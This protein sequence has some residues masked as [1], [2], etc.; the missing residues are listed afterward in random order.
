MPHID[1][2]K[3]WQHKPEAVFD[4]VFFSYY[5]DF[6]SSE[7]ITLSLVGEIKN[8]FTYNRKWNIYVYKERDKYEC[9]RGRQG[10]Y[11]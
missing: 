6:M 1:E 9:R 10:E 3:P 4:S 11:V 2:Q 5:S 7:I 8:M